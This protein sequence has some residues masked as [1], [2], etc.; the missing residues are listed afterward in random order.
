M[1]SK[2]LRVDEFNVMELIGLKLWQ[3]KHLSFYIHF[4][5][6]LVKTRV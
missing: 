4:P 2:R 3:S 5:D 6:K 1:I